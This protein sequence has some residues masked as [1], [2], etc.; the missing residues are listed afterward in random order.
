MT[1]FCD[2][3][4]YWTW[5]K[6]REESGKNVCINNEWI[7][8]IVDPFETKLERIVWNIYSLNQWIFD[9]WKTQENLRVIQKETASYSFYFKGMKYEKWQTIPPCKMLKRNS[10]HETL[11]CKLWGRNVSKCCVFYYILFIPNDDYYTFSITLL[12]ETK[13]RT[14][15]NGHH[16]KG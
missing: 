3:M 10:C 4:Q 1:Q 2:L 15:L 5:E 7:H 14:V 8:W 16:F 9:V 11:R 6:R 13:P 12:R